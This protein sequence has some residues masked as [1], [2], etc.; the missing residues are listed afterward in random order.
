MISPTLHPPSNVRHLGVIFLLGWRV[1]TTMN[2]IHFPCSLIIESCLSRFPRDVLA[3]HVRFELLHY[4]QYSMFMFPL[5]F[6]ILFLLSFDFAPVFSCPL[7]TPQVHFIC[8]VLIGIRF[9][10]LCLCVCICILYALSLIHI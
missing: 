5:H 4:I 3:S 7:S 9:S 6:V 10:S 8:F 2:L 1:I